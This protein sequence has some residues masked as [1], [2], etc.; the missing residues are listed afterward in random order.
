MKM[1]HCG[2]TFSFATS[3][4]NWRGKL[5]RTRCTVLKDD[6]VYLCAL[7]IRELKKGVCLPNQIACFFHVS[8]HIHIK[9][10]VRLLSL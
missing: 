10:A 5:E 7:Q 4:Q 8:V 1:L 2:D 3:S 6:T 9:F